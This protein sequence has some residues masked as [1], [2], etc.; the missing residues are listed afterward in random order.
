LN[1]RG[2]FPSL[3][4]GGSLIAA[5]LCALAVFGGTLAFRGDSP[6]TA[7]A[8]DGSI[9][10]PAGAV[11]AARTASAPARQPVLTARR[12]AATAIATATAPR[13][14]AR[15]GRR[16]AVSLPKPAPRAGTTT[17]ARTAPPTAE[18]P[19]PAAGGGTSRPPEPIATPTGAVEQ[20]VARTR[21]VARPVVDA[22][23]APVQAP[24]NSVADTVE[25]VAGT[26]DQ[27]VGTLL[28]P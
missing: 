20:A 27:T 17:P 11:K 18:P 25:Q 21:A 15:A 16:A 14:Q 6:G 12:T 3:G 9:A 2:L 26:V 19:A 4:A 13:R 28:K 24:V 23:P 8:N 5:A 1:L 7:E 22:A 10:L